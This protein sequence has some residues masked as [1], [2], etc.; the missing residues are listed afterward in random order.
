MQ[1]K[2]DKVIYEKD[3]ENKHLVHLVLNR[4][5]KRNAI[6][7]GPGCMTDQIQQ[8]LRK[9]NDDDDVKVVLLRGNGENFSA[10][11]D[12][13]MVYKVYGGSKD[14]K[15]SQRA[16]L[17]FDEDHITGTRKAVLDC[18]KI[19]VAQ[20]QGWC[21]EGGLYL[22]EAAD[23]AIAAKNARFNHRGQ[24]LVF[25]GTI[26]MSLELLQGN[27]K[28]TVELLITGRTI[29]GEEAEQMGIITRAVEPE[30]LESEVRTLSM[31]LCLHPRDATAIGKMTRRNVMEVLGLSNVLYQAT[32]HTLATNIVYT[33]EE[34]DL[35]FL[36]DRETGGTKAA[37]EKLHKAY[38]EILSQTKYFKSYKPES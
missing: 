34:K 17:R 28:K 31:A 35:V 29:G 7:M 30:I 38:E 22:A 11:F 23:I 26:A 1:K 5:E 15:P 19:V 9:A 32:Y 37:F 10:G 33:P 20:I 24:R 2:D 27:M 14:V 18:K 16:R 3:K 6:S 12:L 25:G 36:K 21:I 13:S 8:A 4:P